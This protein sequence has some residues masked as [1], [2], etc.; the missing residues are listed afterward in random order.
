ML[1]ALARDRGLL[2]AL[3]PQERTRLLNAAG[4]VFNPDVAQRRQWGKAVRR[5]EKAR[6]ARARRG[7][8]RRDRHPRAAR[9]AGVH[10]AER[11]PARR[12]SSRP[13]STDEP[14]LPRG[15]RAAALLRLQAA[16][17]RDPS[18]LRPALPGRAATSTSRKRT[19]DGRPARPRRAAHRR[20]REDRL[21]GRHQAAARGRA[22]DRDDALPARLGGALRAGAGLRGLGRP[23][24]DLRARPAPHAERRGVLPAPARRRAT[25]STSS[26]TTPARPCAARPS[27]TAT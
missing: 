3:S 9:E 14:E 26:S 11:L 8:A 20:A 12:R 15:R 27:S 21:P 4:D 10:D 6:E 13:T 24:R 16:L 7:G 5:R 18:V 25:G 22:P 1:E 17:R 19:R 2:A 23:A